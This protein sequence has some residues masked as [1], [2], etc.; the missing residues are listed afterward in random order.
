MF[1]CV[2]IASSMRSET[3]LGVHLLK[4]DALSAWPAS[5]RRGKNSRTPPGIA[6]AS[7]AAAGTTLSIARYTV[8]LSSLGSII[9]KVLTE[10]GCRERT[11]HGDRRSIVCPQSRA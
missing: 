4:P 9:L 2:S 1:F 6:G 10:L 11:D 8:A 5:S 3:I 7:Q